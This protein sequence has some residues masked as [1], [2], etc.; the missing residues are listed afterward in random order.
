MTTVTIRRDKDGAYRGFTCSG[1]AGYARKGQPDIVCAAVSALVIGAI[2]S[3]EDLAGERLKAETD[4]N[5][6]FIRCEFQDSLQERSVFLLDSMV[7]S[8]ENI[9]RECGTKYLQVK[10]EEV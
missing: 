4:A 6:G 3:L 10:Y 5:T 7:Y 8:L 2:N 9:S 1:H